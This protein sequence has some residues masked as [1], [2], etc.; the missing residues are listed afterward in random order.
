M[1]YREQP[2]AGKS[3]R[4]AKQIV[5]K[6]HL[7]GTPL[8]QFYEE[9]VVQAGEHRVGTDIGPV[10]TAFDPSGVIPLVNPQTGVL[11][12]QSVSHAEVYVILHS[13]Y[14]QVAQARDN[15]SEAP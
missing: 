12:G 6:N 5:I 10:T 11:T 2:V 8:V 15:S 1:D 4:R 9:D 13:L 14:L 3:W 7:G